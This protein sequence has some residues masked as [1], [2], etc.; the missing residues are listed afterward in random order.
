MP[1]LRWVEPGLEPGFP[2]HVPG[3]LY[4]AATFY[5]AVVVY[6]GRSSIQP[7]GNSPGVQVGARL[8]HAS[9]LGKVLLG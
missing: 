7:P 2:I 6:Q 4:H 8:D 9:H 3:L 5:L 1:I